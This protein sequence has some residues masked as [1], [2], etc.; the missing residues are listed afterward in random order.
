M[1]RLETIL[2]VAAPPPLDQAARD[3]GCPPDAVR[4]LERLARIVRL[5]DEIAYAAPAYRRLEATALELAAIAPLTPAA[6]RDA[7]GASR[8]YVMAILEDLDRREVL[9]RTPAGHVPGRRALTAAA[10]L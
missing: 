7:I 5:S 10:R 3:A 1:D 4:E 9:R 6:F 2:D 8:K